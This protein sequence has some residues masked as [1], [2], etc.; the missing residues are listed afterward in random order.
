M[1]LEGNRRISAARQQVWEALNRPEV[2]RRC[3]PGCQRLVV[4][5]AGGYDTEIEIVLGA[6]KGRFTGKIEIKDRVPGS[7]Y[8]LAVSASGSTGFL[9]AEGVV[10]L[11]EE[12]GETRIE[13]TG[14]AEVGGPIAGVGQRMM[15]SVAKRLV[16]QFFET[17]EKALSEPSRRAGIMERPPQP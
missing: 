14:H 9:N 11:R 7:Q 15:D 12:A 10:D 2:L 13:Y 4:N 3:T 16:A 6:I 5:A 8:R 1:K 17:L